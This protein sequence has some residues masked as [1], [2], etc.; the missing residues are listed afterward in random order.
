MHGWATGE[1]ASAHP[2]RLQ[3]SKGVL[4]SLAEELGA[5][6]DT[7]SDH[8]DSV[9]PLFCCDELSNAELLPMFFTKADLAA[10]WVAAGR[11][12]ASVP[13]DLQVTSLQSIVGKMTTD[14][15][16]D[17]NTFML[18]ASEKAAAMAHTIQTR[19]QPAAEDDCPPLE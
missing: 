18:V 11:P 5:S 13:S 8:G 3:P 19:P 7:L 9:F 12:A 16:Y 1:N 15:T 17:W 4:A 2:L 14:T 10:T 6:P